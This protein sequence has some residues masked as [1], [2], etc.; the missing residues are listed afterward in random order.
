[1]ANETTKRCAIYT[2]KSSEEGLQQDYNSLDAQREACEAFIKSQAGEGWHLVRTH[3]FIASKPSR[4]ASS[5]LPLM[6]PTIRPE[7]RSVWCRRQPAVD[8]I[9]SWNA[10]SPS[11]RPGISRRP[12]QR[13]SRPGV[14][15][16][17][18]GRNVIGRR[19]DGAIVTL[20]RAPG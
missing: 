5:K 13:S 20:S 16:S 9:S 1:M 7:K 12:R 19:P 10:C 4:V 15:V 3:P 2:R 17:T 6:R 11:N 8:N 14:T 18:T